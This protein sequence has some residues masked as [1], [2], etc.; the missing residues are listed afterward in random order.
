MKNIRSN[1][2]LFVVGLDGA[3]IK[4]IRKWGL[5]GYLPTLEAIIESSLWGEMQTDT[6]LSHTAVWPNI[7]TG[8]NP[9][10]HGIYN[11]YQA[12]PDSYDIYRVKAEQCCQPSFWKYLNECGIKCIIFD[13]PFDRIIKDFHGIQFTEW[14]SWVKYTSMTGRPKSIWN[15]LNKFISKPPIENEVTVKPHDSSMKNQLKSWL[16]QG[17]QKKTIAVEW[18]LKSKQWDFFFVVFPE[19]HPAA[20]FFWHLEDFRNQNSCNSIDIR[21]ENNL[22]EIYQSI[23]RSIGRLMANLRETDGLIILSGDCLR[24]CFSAW[25]L[26]PQLLTRF[27]LMVPKNTEFTVASGGEVSNRNDLLF[28][29]RNHIPEP[30]RKLILKG[31]PAGIKFKMWQSW[32]RPDLDWTQTKAYYVPNDCQG[33]LRIN[34]IGR[35]PAGIIK[36]KN[37]FD[38]L[39]QEIEDKFLSLV[40]PE[41]N[42][43]VVK[44]VIRSARY[45]S[46]Q[47]T[48]QLPDIIILWDDKAGICNEIFSQAT[49]YIPNTSPVY[50]LPPFYIG[51]HKGPGF[52][53]LQGDDSPVGRFN[54]LLEG[55]D[56][57]PTILSFFGLDVPEN[58]DG[59]SFIQ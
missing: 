44:Q 8:T 38:Y 45:F 52:V 39:C 55:Y 35:E 7:I 10:K 11:I 43:P 20:H 2:R 53:M 15:D 14:G 47:C 57:A 33:H 31:I 58:Y 13:A 29:L 12:C 46:G 9:G 40:N 16:V 18:L 6:E 27:D 41:N 30:V 37:E 22:L 1:R 28:R 5:S 59:R 51:N 56:I 50:E 36:Q 34:L 24:P 21:P 49:G 26:I 54:K 3:D 19:I 4:L 32:N 42:R 17:I 48:D 25:H 23:D